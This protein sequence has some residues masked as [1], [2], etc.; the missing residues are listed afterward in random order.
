MRLIHVLKNNQEQ[1]T[2][3]WI[4]HLKNLR[5]EDMIQQLA[6]QDKNF[7]N[8]LQQLNELKIFIGDPEHILGSYLTKHGEIAEHVQVRFC[9]ADK[10]LVGKAANHT[11]EGV[12]RTAME[13]YLRNGKMIQSKFYNG[14]KG[15]FNAIVTHLKSYPY[16]IKKGGSYDIPRDQY[17]S[18]I[19]IYNRGQTA[20]SSLSR[21]EETLF[22]HMIAWE[23]EQDVKICDVVH[24]TQVDYK[25]VQLKVVDRTVKDKET[26]IEQKNEG[27]K[28]RIKDQHKPSMQ[29]G[30][31]ATALAA[32][33][34]GGTT[35]C[36]KVYEKRKAGRKLSEFTTNDWK[37]VGIDTAKGTTKGAIRGSSVFAMT[38]FLNSPAPV[39]NSL[40]TA[41]FGVVSLARKLENN[42]ITKEEFTIN[43]EVVCLEVG[44]SAL[45]AMLGQTLVPIPVLGAIVGNTVGMLMLEISR[46][47]LDSDEQQLIQEYVTKMSALDN[48][49]VEEYSRLLKEIQNKEHKFNSLV[50]LAFD[51]DVNKAFYS[52]VALALSED[53]DEGMILKNLNDIDSYFN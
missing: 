36:I 38:N 45:S 34:E 47:Y 37:E 50:E 23:N 32:G 15:T 46:N 49:Y 41:T 1:A 31:Q 26:K 21:S 8:A 52:S 7:E 13:D 24:P 30:L 33:L 6:R 14:V 2:A 11:F 43:S 53:V 48:K 35:F 9:N 25:D 39:A 29:E 40:V 10:L 4:D 16:F 44:T 19:D 51:K 20:R 5:I 17:E 27:I 28:D 3:A 22:K 12:G 18:L 42:Q